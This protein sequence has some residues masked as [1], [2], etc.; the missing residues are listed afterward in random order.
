MENQ[1]NNATV[2]E[3]IPEEKTITGPEKAPVNAAAEM[4]GEP[5]APAKKRSW[6][7]YVI[8]LLIGIGA[9]V[10]YM[11]S[12]DIW[13]GLEAKESLRVVSDGFFISGS[14]IVCIGAFVFVTQKGVF[15]AVRYAFG[16]LVSLFRKNG[17]TEK[18][19]SYAHYKK[20]KEDNEKLN[21]KPMMLSGLAILAVG[22]VL[23]AIYMN[24]YPA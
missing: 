1:E 7:A 4:P 22:L 11:S 15:D 13:K 21:L 3:Q 8:W 10:W 17:N 24:R 12:H 9:A 5:P 23:V 20:S 2:P 14:L 6:I 18:Y 16:S 19:L